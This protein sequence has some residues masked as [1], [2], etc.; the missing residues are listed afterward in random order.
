MTAPHRIHVSDVHKSI[1]L[2]VPYDL[3]HIVHCFYTFYSTIPVEDDINTWGQDYTHQNRFMTVEQVFKCLHSFA[4]NL[5]E[6]DSDAIR[7]RMIG[8]ITSH[9]SIP[10][11]EVEAC[12]HAK[13]NTNVNVNFK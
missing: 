3:K 4:A 9:T 1:Q 8:H 7:L 12:A 10:Y 6:Q 13:V 2:S 5:S 11:E